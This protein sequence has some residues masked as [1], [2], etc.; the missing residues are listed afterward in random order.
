MAPS[1]L[2]CLINSS[3]PIRTTRSSI[4]FW[5]RE[6]KIAL[7]GY[8]KRTFKMGVVLWN[9]ITDEHLK[10]S[11]TSKMQLEAILFNGYNNIVQWYDIYFILWIIL[12]VKFQ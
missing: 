1:Y 9:G 10:Q 11:K 6:P 3:K 4:I 2:D 8:G 7:N 12:Y 5:A